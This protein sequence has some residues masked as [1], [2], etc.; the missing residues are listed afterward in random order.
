[1]KIVMDATITGLDLYVVIF[2]A[3][4]RPEKPPDLAQLISWNPTL[5]RI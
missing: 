5:K 3:T 4:G 1:M 2:F